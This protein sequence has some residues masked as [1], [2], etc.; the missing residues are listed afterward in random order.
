MVEISPAAANSQQRSRVLALQKTVGPIA[1]ISLIVG[2]MIGS[3]IFA[4]ARWVLVYAGSGGLTLIIWSLCGV[5]SIFGALSYLELGLA[6]PKSG[7]EY[8]YL[9]EGYGPLPAFMFAWTTVLVN[10][11]SALAIILLTFASYVIEAIFPGCSSR[12][13]MIPLTKLLA[14][15]AIGKKKHNYMFPALG[16][17]PEKILLTDIKLGWGFTVPGF[18]CRLLFDQRNPLFVLP[19]STTE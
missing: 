19:T 3:G 6:I 8:T 18:L 7:G 17:E 14:A 9:R 12:Q 13:E 4:S 11:P 10:K 1:G 15:S 2:I 16:H 5:L